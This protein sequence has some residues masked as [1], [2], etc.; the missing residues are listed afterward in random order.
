MKKNKEKTIKIVTLDYL[1][2][3]INSM[4]FN[5]TNQFLPNFYYRKSKLCF[6]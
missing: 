4:K 3:N 6:K 2:L 5:K 1:I